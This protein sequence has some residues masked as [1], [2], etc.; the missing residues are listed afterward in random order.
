MDTVDDV[1]R[2]VSILPVQRAKAP[3]AQISLVAVVRGRCAPVGEVRTCF[4]GSRQF[5]RRYD[6]TATP[7]VP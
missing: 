7:P 5:N 6:M 1:N 4:G 2:N 3:Q